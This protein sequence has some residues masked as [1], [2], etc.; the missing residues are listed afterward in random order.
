[1]VC[2]CRVMGWGVVGERRYSDGVVRVWDVSSGACVVTLNGHKGAI[3]ALCFDG[4]GGLLASGSHDTDVIIWDLA[5]E[6]GLFRYARLMWRTATTT[7]SRGAR[8]EALSAHGGHSICL[9]A[10][11]SVFPACAGTRA[12]SQG[13]AF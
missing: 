11:F 6:A 8:L 3:T 7:T 2:E 1:V 4:A 5:A 10:S 9:F 13:C 12:T